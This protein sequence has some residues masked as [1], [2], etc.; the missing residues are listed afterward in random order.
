MEF[1]TSWA[2]LSALQSRLQTFAL[3]QLNYWQT[4]RECLSSGLFVV[5]RIRIRVATKD[6][7]PDPDPEP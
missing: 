1:V 5:L 6:A 7:Q 4:G 2:L 3:P